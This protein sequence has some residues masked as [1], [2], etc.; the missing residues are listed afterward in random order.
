M[1]YPMP[2]ATAVPA[3]G[4]TLVFNF[5]APG[6]L[7]IVQSAK[8][9]TGSLQ[10]TAAPSPLP[11]PHASVPPSSLPLAGYSVPALGAHTQYEVLDTLASVGP[12]P[13]V[14]IGSFTTK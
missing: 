3:G 7:S 8:S 5:A 14:S 10:A 6:T 1:I 2:G 4:F 13:S 9:V 11:S 12:C